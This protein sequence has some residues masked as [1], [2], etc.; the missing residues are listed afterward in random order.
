MSLTQTL[1]KWRWYQ[2]VMLVLVLLYVLYIALSYLYLP[3]KLKQVVETDVSELIGRGIEVERIDFNPFALSLTVGKFVIQDEPQYPIVG[4]QQFYGDFSFWRSLF[5]LQIAFDS[6]VLDQPQI[7][8]VQTADGFNFNDI[9]ERLAANKEEQPEPEESSGSIALQVASSAINSGAFSFR[10]GSGKKVAETQV[11]GISVVVEDLYFA[12][13]DQDLNPFNINARFPGGG[14]VEL[15]GQYRIDPLLVE[16]RFQLKQLQMA[17]FSDFVENRVPVRISDGALFADAKIQLQ[18][19]QEFQLLLTQGNVTLKQ[20]A[21]DDEVLTPPMLRSESLKI[22]NIN[23]DLLQRKFTVGSILQQGLEINQW[24]DAEGKPRYESLLKAPSNS[25]AQDAESGKGESPQEPPWQLTVDTVKLDNGTINLVKTQQ[26]LNQPHTLSQLNIQLNNITLEQEQKTPLLVSGVLDQQGKIDLKGDLVLFPF[27]MGLD[28]QLDKIALPPFTQY[29]ESMTNLRLG[30]GSTSVNGSVELKVA[31]ELHLDTALDF[32]L[33]DFQVENLRTGKPVV[34]LEQLKLDQLNV[35][36]PS[37]QIKLQ[38]L[39]LNKPKVYVVRDSKGQ[40]NLASLMK[41]GKYRSDEVGHEK[42][43]EDV[44]VATEAKPWNFRVGKVALKSGTT[45]FSDAS[46]SPSF[47]TGLYSMDLDVGEIASSG[48]QMIPIK[49]S[50]K[51]DRYAP[52]TIDGHLQPLQKQ[53]GFSIKS[54][55]KGLDLPNLSPY[56]GLYIGN[57]LA[58]GKLDLDLSYDLA[59]RQLKGKNNIQADNLYLGEKVASEQAIDAPVGLGLALLRGPSGVIDLNVGVGG[60]LDDPNFSVAGVVVKALV[61]VIVKAATSPFK[62]LGSLAGGRED[63][64]EIDFTPGAAQLDEENR[65]RLED[66]VTALK[67]RPQLMIRFSGN[68]SA[69]EDAQ[70]LKEIKLKAQVS[71]ERRITVEALEQA[72]TDGSW[73]QVKD[74]WKVLSSI[75]KQAQLLSEKDRREAIRQK[76]PE[77]DSDKVVEIAHADLF[78]ELLTKQ[79]VSKAD[80]VALADQRALTVKQHMV[81]VLE[82]KHERVAVNKSKKLQGR[83][84][85]LEIDAR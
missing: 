79:E 30:K 33:D 61:N 9:L 35:A 16:S 54:E 85:K 69:A 3:G 51:I 42:D 18:S 63:L 74:N 25:N 45:I 44:S 32:S 59:E 36:L 43:G 5:G 39:A 57:Q 70:V 29:L 65:K 62:L 21:M 75:A 27:S 17:S 13:G 53:P 73:W 4:W 49:F 83:I 7:N 78:Q 60:D 6:L 31:D 82:L 14:Q 66:L 81:D 50:S 24:V 34:K 55:L 46:V 37:Q 67:Q 47:K 12:T 40:I 48:Q 22:E 77:L 10:D 68:A 38:Q 80:L 11:D 76:Q 58:S 84:I 56:S 20:L 15:N 23:L 8:I 28:Y 64:G 71:A 26:S 41:S 52:L 1:K 2:W 19:D 72:V